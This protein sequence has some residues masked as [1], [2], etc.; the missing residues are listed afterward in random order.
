MGA[1]ARCALDRAVTA[2]TV[3]ALAAVSAAGWVLTASWAGEEPMRAVPFV[4]AWTA[5]MAAMM[6][7]SVAPLVLLHRRRGRTASL[8]AGYLLVWAAFGVPVYALERSLG[9]MDVSDVGV[10]AVLAAAGVYQ[11]TPLKSACL[12]R[13]R[14]PVDFLIARYRAGAFR[15]GVEHGAYCVGCCVGL[16]ALLVVAGA[17]GIVW[18]AAIAAAVFLE[19]VLP[20]GERSARASGLVLLVLAVVYV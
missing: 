12:R 8:L 3:A 11:L 19:K 10:A 7:P 16:M 13:C 2:E 18:A 5:M 17:M 6:T 1:A 15:L 14:S 20:W 4:A 9:L